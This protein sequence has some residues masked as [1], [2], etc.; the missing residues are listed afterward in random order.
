MSDWSEYIQRYEERNW[1]DLA[2]AFIEKYH[3]EC[4]EFVSEKFFR[5]SPSEQIGVY[6]S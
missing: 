6:E 1:E 3:K 4:Y 2:E 5:D